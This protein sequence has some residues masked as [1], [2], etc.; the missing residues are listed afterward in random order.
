[1]RRVANIISIS[2][3]VSFCSFGQ[4]NQ[5]INFN[6]D[7]FKLKI[8][9]DGFYRVTSEELENEGFPTANVAASRIK[10]YRMGEEVSLRVF[11]N[12]DGV[13]LD[14][15]EF[16]GQKNDGI[17]DQDLYL[18]DA[19]PHQ[20]L[21]LFSDTATFFLTWDNL[22]SGKRIQSSNI[23]DNL[24]LPPESYHLE[25][26]RIIQR[27]NYHEG[28]RFGAGYTFHLSDYDQGEGWTGPFIGK[29]GNQTFNFLL[30]NYVASAPDPQL[31]LTL[32]GGNSLT[33][34]VG[35]EVGPD[36]SSLTEIDQAQFANYTFQNHQ[37]D[38]PGTH[39]GP[40]GELVIRL[41]VLGES[42]AADRVSVAQVSLTYPQSIVIPADEN[43]L[44]VSDIN[45]EERAY[46]QVMT[47]SPGNYEFYDITDRSDPIKLPATTL[48]SRADIVVENPGVSHHIY[49]VTSWKNVPKIEAYSFS[50]IN[51]SDND[52]LIITHPKLRESLDGTDQVLAYEDYRESQ[53]GGNYN[54]V[55]AQIEDVYDQFNY[56]DPSS[57]A[58]R[59][60]LE[61]AYG[62]IEY[63]FIIGKGRTVNSDFF[64]RFP[65][66][67]AE[68][69]FDPVMIPTYGLPGGDLRFSTGLDPGNPHA[70][71]IP[72]GRLSAS[73]N[74]HVGAYL[75][76]V[77][78]FEAQPFDVLWR[79]NLIQLS[80]GQDASELDR[81][82]GY[83]Q[84]FKNVAE[85]DFLGGRAM[86]QGKETS[87]IFEVFPI[88]EEVNAGV[89]M[90]TLFGHS[91]NTVT[92]IEIG[93][94]SNPA[95]GY[96]NK[97]KYPF[98]LVNGCRAGEI[99]VNTVSFGED[100]MREADKGCIGFIAHADFA[101]STNLR[102]FT[103]I[104]YEVAFAK[105]ESF[106][107]SVGEILVELA[108][109]Y[110]DRDGTGDAE[111]TQ[112]HQTLYQ[113]DP[114]IK[115]FGAIQADFQIEDLSVFASAISGDRI[116]SQQDSFNINLVVKNFGRTV[117][118]SLNVSIIR[119]LPNGETVT[120]ER[121]FLPPRYRDTLS[122]SISNSGLT[123][124]DGENSFSISIDPL[125]RIEELDEMNNGANI[126]LFIAEGN[127][128]NLL[129]QDQAL[130]RNGE[131][132]LI[133]QPLDILTPSR[134]YAVE[135]DSTSDFSS[136]F[137]QQFQTEGEDVLEYTVDF[138]GLGIQDTTVIYWRTRF[139]N[140]ANNE[141]TLW[142]GSSFALVPDSVSGWAQMDFDQFS[143]N[144]FQG[145]QIN[146]SFSLLEFMTNSIPVNIVTQ[147]TG[148]FNYDDNQVI[149]N[150]TDLL[151]TI[152]VVDPVC[153][154][155]TI[156]AIALDRT[157]NAL[158]RPITFDGADVFQPLVCGKLPQMIYNLDENDVL[159]ARRIEELISNLKFSDHLLLFNLDSVAYS[160][161]DDQILDALET[162]GVNRNDIASLI[163]GQPVV[164][165][166][167]KGLAP[168]EAVILWD[169]GSVFP[170]KE[171]QLSFNEDV[172]GS[173]VDGKISFPLIGPAKQWDSLYYDFEIESDD[174]F[175]VSISGV[176]V[177]GNKS[178][179]FNSGRVE[180]ID[181]S[182]LDALQYPFLEIEFEL[183]DEISLTP[184]EF[185]SL[186]VEFDPSPEGLVFAPDK[187]VITV[188]EGQ[189]ITATVGIRN[190]SDIAYEDS[191]TVN[192]LLRNVNSGN[193]TAMQ[194]TI[195]APDPKDTVQTGFT[196]SSIGMVGAND[197]I[198][199]YSS[200]DIEI[201]KSNNRLFMQSHVTVEEDN[202][203]PVLDVTFDGAYI[204]NGDIVSSDPVIFVRLKDRN[205]YLVKSDTSG[206]EIE[207]KP[208]GEGA[209]YQRV[210]MTDPK[211]SWTTATADEDFELEYKPGPLE[212][213][214][215]SLR[216]QASD[217]TGNLVATEPFEIDF[218]VI[219]ESTV[220]HFYPYPNPFSTSCRFVFTLTGSELPDNIKIQ[221]MTI[222]GRVVRE[223]MQDEIGP[224]R[225]GDN[226]TEYAW[227]G[228]DQYGDLLANGVYLY[229]VILKSGGRT[230]EHRSTVADRSFEH[231]F[232]KLY[233]LR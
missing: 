178:P 223:I 16:W 43:K 208:P 97:G 109:E 205:P 92:D 52:F 1:M 7:Y 70:P 146:E 181:I 8:S 135:F 26:D 28:R 114:A 164:I 57:I 132:D 67:S 80:G 156:N 214:V 202:V 49:A 128:V 155:N 121:Q 213:G 201:T 194:R 211:I 231:G 185:K 105:E 115:V 10:L 166:G 188:Q 221:I 102:L 126:S 29:G 51:Y 98:I 13:T 35:I 38:V 168:G 142:I 183:G 24:G 200:S 21:N 15:F 160:N 154:T 112:V 104:F 119:T 3:L 4:P 133:W 175:G 9:E 54:V 23:G 158:F 118:D 145:I 129:P 42:G 144:N 220:T 117:T 149:I 96:N 207:L 59:R 113:G 41:T 216:V 95:D 186:G 215:H 18:P 71:A 204:M 206:I 172:V 169:N 189:D 87:A 174:T 152:N 191:I 116:L 74:E 56:G 232:G 89:G 161:W 36:E 195:A 73:T 66:D 61:E 91:S 179:F 107:S 63:V 233:I 64:R 47:D 76:K 182:T 196:L 184:P 110:F 55:I 225:I 199:E 48:I 136:P 218:E 69:L 78:E 147:G 224:V 198:V 94:V 46:F 157:S 6:Q 31:N 127:T 93:R 90:I 153:K 212:D 159:S 53:A 11:F 33:H 163:D 77:I 138:E 124:V 82:A 5:W 190:V 141:D 88:A 17:S 84:N 60:L 72:I 34:I 68:F 217:E 58:I 2:L 122:F 192:F 22:T 228:R 125:N 111:K 173:E 40:G 222:S 27:T 14:Y 83:I 100:W 229:R 130:V 137:F 79:K 187:T 210:S 162:I 197:L 81:F 165:L 123:S 25:T 106:G 45:L 39:V 101:L 227:D 176:D 193:V 171:Q 134:S 86:N 203:N 139:A 230:F 30:D 180:K 148:I 209:T 20:Y 143:A 44:F 19:Q 99:F 65:L 170:P 32:I 62:N 177:D 37:V 151:N 75:N 12:E 85:G 103:D 150:G 108:K 120:Y 140:P 226:I 167:R 219:N 131:V 50:E